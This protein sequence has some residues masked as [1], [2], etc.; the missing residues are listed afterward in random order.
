MKQR[1]LLVPFLISMAVSPARAQTSPDLLNQADLQI[2]RLPP[3]AFPELTGEIVRDLLSRGCT[4]PQPFA[5]SSPENVIHGEFAKPDQQDWA[6]LCSVNRMSSILIFWGGSTR[7]VSEVYKDA[8][9]NRLQSVGN[10]EIGYS[11]GISPA[12]K[13]YIESH[14]ALHREAAGVL[15]PPPI[16]HEGINDAFLGKASTVHY[17]FQ[18]KWVELAGAD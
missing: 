9:K 18:G 10:D 5:S 3:T 8:D 13:Q 11:R 12:G 2:K 17:F 7:D 14:Y 6:V 16:D 15:E 4:I 1:L